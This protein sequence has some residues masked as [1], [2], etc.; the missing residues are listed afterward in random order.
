MKQKLCALLFLLSV[1]SS[2]FAQFSI[3]W[4]NCFG[5][6]HQDIPYDIIE[7]QGNYLIIGYTDS[8]DGDISYNH[9]EQ[10]VW[11]VEVDSAG[12]MIREK[13]FGGSL[14]DGGVRI[15]KDNKGDL[16]LL[17][18]AWSSD[19]DISYD[20]YPESGDFWTVKID[21][22]W[23]IIWDKILGGTWLDR[24]QTGT[25]T[26]DGNVIVQGHTGS[27]DGDVSVYYGE[28]DIWQT[29]LSNNGDLL[30]DFTLG[31][32][33]FDYGHSLLQTSDNGFL[34]GG[35]ARVEDGGG[36]IE[37]VPHSWYG[38]AILAKLDS[39][40]SIEWQHCYGGSGD[41]QVNFILEVT[42]GYILA[43]STMSNDGDLA[44]AGYH[45]GLDVWIIKIDFFGNI[46]WSK[47]YGG[48]EHDNPKKMFPSADGGFLIFANTQSNDG[49]VNGNHQEGKDDIWVVKISEYG[50]LEW[51]QCFGG[52]GDERI[53]HAVLKINEHKY[54]IAAETDNG[55]SFDV[56]CSPV[57]WGEP[58]YWVLELTDSMVGIDETRNI[59]DATISVFPNPSNQFITIQ[60][61]LLKTDAI[62]RIHNTLGQCMKEIQVVQNHEGLSI[63][64]SHF[65]PG[66][67]SIS[68][69]CKGNFVRTGLI[70][71]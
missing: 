60:S 14:G 29:K 69:N 38:E 11:V 57:W 12:N 43:A 13:T 41:E 61:P 65:P 32:L 2:S 48:S 5:G 33:G 70:V 55:P 16:Y 1:F 34:V 54:I 24:V 7:Y 42:D 21:G 20:P 36:N 49:D 23:D 25:M 50:T 8:Y 40:A 51:Q 37:C 66:Y 52:I 39:N 6:S 22:S 28:Y 4:Q 18:D 47:C 64:I 30:W 15:L 19:G 53:W 62:I 56:D 71:R 35:Y 10:D 27:P 67:Y 46:L 45:G 31:S 59:D 44:G 26:H 9:G 17:G 3:S 58:K 68:L 63:D